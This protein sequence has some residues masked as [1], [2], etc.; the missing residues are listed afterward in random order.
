M[1]RRLVP[2]LQEAG[3]TAAPPPRCY[4]QRRPLPRLGSQGDL[5]SE[6]HTP[7]P[8][9]VAC[10]HRERAPCRSHKGSR[11]KAGFCEAPRGPSVPHA[12][13]ED[14]DRALGAGDHAC[15]FGRVRKL[16]Q[17]RACSVPSKAVMVASVSIRR[18]LRLTTHPRIWKGVP[19]WTGSLKRIRSSAV[20]ASLPVA[21][22]AFDI[23]PSST[24][25][26]TPPWTIP[27]KPSHA[28]AGVHVAA[29]PPST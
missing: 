4:R 25:L 12:R 27:R 11:G 9:R 3:L 5:K 6:T 24:V 20:K 8:F 13:V 16:A 15:A 23:A 18:L 28:G 21:A 26:T 22:T 10:A 2:V 7:P 17:A 29:M 1:A 14:A 19:D